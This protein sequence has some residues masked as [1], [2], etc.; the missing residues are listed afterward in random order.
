MN[1]CLM[2]VVVNKS[3]RNYFLK[4]FIVVSIALAILLNSGSEAYALSLQEAR[5]EALKANMDIKIYH[6]KNAEAYLASEEG[7]T[8]L[9]PVFSLN[10]TAS[11]VDQENA[12]KIEQGLYGV[13]PFGPIPSKDLHL[14]YQDNTLLTIASIQI[15]Q[16]ISVGNRIYNTYKQLQSQF[17][18]AQWNEQQA[19]QDTLFNIEKAYYDLLKAKEMLNSA[20]LHEKTLREHLK[21][22]EQKYQKGSSA[23]VDVLQVKVQVA[24]AE[25]EAL[26]NRNDVTTAEDRV[27]LILNRPLDIPVDPVPLTKSQEVTIT[28]DEATEIAKANNK[29]LISARTK[30]ITAK[31]QRKVAEAD[32]YP[33]INISTQ[34]AIQS[35]QP[36]YPNDVWSV[37]VDASWPIFQWGGTKHRVGAAQAYVQEMLYRVASLENQVIAKVRDSFF[38]IEET[39]KKIV[40]DKEAISAAEET[41]RITVIGFDKGRKTS[42]DVL[43]AEDSLSKVR[44]SYIQDFYDS[45]TARAQLRYAMGKMEVEDFLNLRM[46]LNLERS[47]ERERP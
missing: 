5:E 37:T 10:G 6:E 11:Y 40:I 2:I 19:M 38:Q 27:N 33:D 21:D 3:I 8:K 26:K 7:F 14:V 44:T 31:I 17:Q 39:D 1:S 4:Y 43:N 23:L 13:Y 28:R 25:G 15:Q 16:P 29:V 35:G 45:F 24:Q 18:E 20:K 12:I 47:K 34:Y 36:S 9:L 22:I 30:V 42:T 32:Y 46:A 41:L